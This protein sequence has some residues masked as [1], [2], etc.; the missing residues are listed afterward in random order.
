MYITRVFFGAEEVYKN[1]A[2][3]FFGAGEVS[4]KC[5]YKYFASAGEVYV[6]T[7]R[8]I[9]GAGEVFIHFFGAGEVGV[10]FM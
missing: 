9:F 3:A 8:A 1:S 6:N 5:L 7:G 10:V 2:M 4:D